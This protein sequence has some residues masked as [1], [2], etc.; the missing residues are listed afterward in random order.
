MVF[1]MASPEH[2]N[3]HTYFIAVFRPAFPPLSPSS[4]DKLDT[5]C[6]LEIL[7]SR[8]YMRTLL[9]DF[10]QEISQETNAGKQ[11]NKSSYTPTTEHH[12]AIKII[13]LNWQLIERIGVYNR[14]RN[15]M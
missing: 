8:F 11:L 1:L 12:A 3:T 5:L 13:S 9:G 6:V 4:M 7:L 10:H 15:P 2:P 14:M